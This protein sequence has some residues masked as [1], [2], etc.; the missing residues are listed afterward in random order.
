MFA[1][2]LVGAAALRRSLPPWLRW[3]ALVGFCATLFSLLISAYL[4]VDVVNPTAYA[5]KILGVT[6]LSN[7]IGIGFFKLRTT[8]RPRQ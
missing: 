6:L 8:S 4:F 1:V 3:V 5:V 2:P 7:L